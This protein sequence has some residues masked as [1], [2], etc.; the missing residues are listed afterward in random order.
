M[1]TKDVEITITQMVYEL[2]KEELD[3]IKQKS[4]NEGLNDLSNY[5]MYCIRNSNYVFNY[6]YAMKT[7]GRLFDFFTGKTN[8]IEN[9]KNIT[10]QQFINGKR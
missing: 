5:I 9:Q 2:T 8:M 6:G 10:F 1:K 4:Y 7:I 3:D